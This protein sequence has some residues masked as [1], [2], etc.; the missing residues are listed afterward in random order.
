VV[1]RLALIKNTAIEWISKND[2]QMIDV[3]QKVWEWAELG[4]VEF[5]SSELIARTLEEHGFSVERGVAGMPTAFVAS[6]GDS[7][8]VLGVMGEY[9]ALPGISQ[10]PTTEKEPLAEGAPG[11][12]CG[13]NI[14]GA[15]GMGAAIA[16][17]MALEK[18]NLPGTVKF[19]GCPAEENYSGKVFMVRDGLFDDVDVALSHHPGWTNHAGLTSS[20]SVNSVKFHFH[21]VSSHA[22]ASP[23]RG[24]SALDAAEL[25]NIGVNFMREHVVQEARLHYVIEKGGEQ[26]NVVPPYARSWYYIRA[27]ER[28]Q[29]DQ[30]HDWVLEIADGADLMARTTHEV[31]F[32]EGTYNLL[33]NKVLSELVTSN[34]REI[35]SPEYNK[36]EMGF[37]KKIAKTITREDKEAGLRQTKRPQWEK[38]MGVIMDRSIP[39]A[40]DEGEIMPGSTDV[41]DVSWTTPT[42]EFST[43]TCVLGVPFHSWQMV[44][45]CGMSIGH[46]SLLFAAK[47]LAAA[48]LDLLTKPELL[49]SVRQDFTERKAG[50]EYRCPIPKEVAPPLDV[51][52]EAA[53]IS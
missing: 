31:E 53:G 15:S 35:G 45:L 26:P 24:K 2:E 25:M 29:V 6:Y 37:A 30:I 10:K 23:D 52:K 46:K 42:M 39:D 5:K 49:K 51:A 16:V 28:S 13:H 20:L 27:P 3:S 21:G 33:P 32:L 9:D 17:R 18:H 22:A 38:L 47:T 8:P 36:K 48:G 40:W 34:M 43:A 7:G 50:R 41:S 1:E 12:G 14:H 11:H 4:L 19:F 44:S